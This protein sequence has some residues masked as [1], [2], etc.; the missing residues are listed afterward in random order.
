MS[1]HKIN[2]HAGACFALMTALLLG[3]AVYSQSGRQP[4]SSRKTNQDEPLKL[5][6]EE[7]LLNVTVI[8]PY[9]H[10]ATD[11][12]KD[13]F[14]VAEDGQRQDIASF[15]L[16]S[17]P[18][19]VV[20]LLDASGS[21]VTEINSLRDAAMHFVNQLSPEDKTSVIEFHTNLELIQDWTSKADEVRH[22]LS[23]RF[24]PG[25][26]QTKNGS[27]SYGSTALF[28]AL[29]S[30]ADEQL[31]KVE[32]R[33]AIIL[34][35][36]GD[37]TS[38]KLTYQQAAASIT[39]SGAV[40]YVISKARRFINELEKYRGKAGRVFGGGLS[41]QA[42]MMASRFERAERL[43]TELATRSGGRIY[44]PLADDE[45]KSVYAQV[46]REL[47]NQYIVTYV[48][49][50]LERDGRLRRVSVYL[51]RSGYSART[52]DSYYAP[53]K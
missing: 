23:W 11:L 18:V 24:K 13:E 53:K 3:T 45:M 34:L 35:S 22:A 1:T 8:D 10:Q 50:N 43:M 16:S 52:R 36:D 42:E 2:F 6:A 5:R 20:L 30:T 12:N 19:N 32:G 26:V 7:V 44:S 25:M 40:V 27:F 21:V 41:Q 9:G 39:R 46:A 49:K 4:N 48:P 29:Y 51:T 17:V 37:D 31:A 33:K 14:I 15:I 38:S 28:D 47:K